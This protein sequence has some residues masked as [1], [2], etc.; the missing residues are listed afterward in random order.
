MFYYEGL[1]CPVCSKFFTEE[2]DVVVCPQCGLPH[3]RS[4]W[5]SIGRCYEE[6]KHGTD[7][8]WSREHAQSTTPPPHAQSVMHVCP[9]CDA[10]NAEYAEFCT[11]C[12]YPLDVEDWH[13]SAPQ[14]HSPFVGEY[15]PYGQPHE[16]YSSA[17][18]IGE[19]NAADLAAVVGSNTQYYIE[20]FRR[21]EHNGS[22]GWN[23]AAFLLAPM[24]L[25]YRKQYG[26]G[27]VYLLM[28]LMS[29][30]VSAVIY[31]PMRV[32]ETQAAAEVAL[33]NMMDSPLFW[34]AAVLSC[35]FFALEI[36]LGMRANHFYLRHCE[37][38]IAKIRENVSDLSVAELTAVGG[39]SLGVAVLVNVLASILLDVIT[40]AITTF[41]I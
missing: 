4:C 13:S 30:V 18:R 14:Q 41:F 29:G 32:A 33:T 19:S 11:R 3:H 15:T 25:F 28:Q 6:D 34:L 38:K 1:S 22:G 39:V 2:D 8:Q 37:K 27:T 35:I 7:Q 17:E 40:I 23:W 36:L 21:I 5:K 16:S 12:G 31:A 10:Q 9:H 26:L 20:R 24:W